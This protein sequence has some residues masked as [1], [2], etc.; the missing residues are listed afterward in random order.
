MLE[1]ADKTLTEDII[2]QMH[3]LLKAGTTDSMPEWFAVGD[4]KRRPNMV[5][6][7]D[8]A[9]PSNVPKEMKQLVQKYRKADNLTF[10]DIISFH[11]EFEKI[12]PFQDGNGRV[13]RLI[14]FKECLKNEIVPF[15]IEDRSKDFY[16]RGLR[17]FSNERGYLTETC[18]ASQDAYRQLLN[19]FEI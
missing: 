1:I 19:Y 5:G 6:G 18:R 2:K 8:T 17:E 15:I 7:M 14:M 4:Y 16:Y 13:G 10:D 3:R 9:H 12:H 11:Y